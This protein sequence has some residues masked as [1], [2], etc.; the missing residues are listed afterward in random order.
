MEVVDKLGSSHPELVRR[1]TGLLEAAWSRGW[2]LDIVSSTRSY[3]S[4]KSLYTAW[5]SGLRSSIAANP[6]ALLGTAPISELLKDNGMWKV[7][8]SM[9]MPQY[10]GYSHAIDVAIEGCT[11]GEL[12]ALAAQY[13]LIKT[14]PTENW[15]LQWWSCSRG[16]FPTS[17]PIAKE[18]DDMNAREMAAALGATFN[19]QSGVIEIPLLESY[20]PATG[21]ATFKH[22]PFAAAITYTHQ[23]LKIARARAQGMPV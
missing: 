8:G 19:E 7:W 1:F 5:R 20:D 23:E 9:H 15:H 22:Y 13:G 6:D 10:D 11:W 16:V 2:H 4:Q 17:L 3:D 21:N 14:E 12:H 18:E